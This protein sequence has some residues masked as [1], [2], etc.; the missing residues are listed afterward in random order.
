MERLTKI[1]RLRFKNSSE[2]GTS[3]LG[4]GFEK[5]DRGVFDPSKA[6]DKVAATGVKWIRL[7]SGWQRT[8]REKG[9]Y[10]W[11]WLD[12]VVDNLV[13]RGL[14]PWACLCYGNDLYSPEAKQYYGAV[15][16]PPIRTEEEKAAWHNYVKALTARYRGRMT[17]YE[18]WNEPDGKWCWKHGVN[19]R[20]YAQFVIDTARAVREG[21]PDAKV[22]GGSV[23]ISEMNFIAEAFEAGMGTAI[24]ALTYHAY[25]PDESTVA[26]R[27]RVLRGICDLYNPK[28]ELIQGESGSQSRSGGHGALWS[29]SWTQTKQAK[30]LLRHAMADLFTEAKF[31]SYFSC[32]DMI[33]A[34][35]GS[36]DNVNSILDYGYFGILG[37]DFDEKGFATGEYRPKDSYWALSSLATVFGGD[38]APAALPVRRMKCQSDRV[39]G[40]DNTLDFDVYS[41]GFRR[42]DGSAA[43]VYWKSTN[44]MTTA[45]DGTGTFEVTGLKD[46]PRLVDLYDGS[47]YEFPETLIE[48]EN[49]VVYQLKNIPLRD[50]PLA[51][52]FGNFE[53]A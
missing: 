7:Q 53:Q 20:E 8:E 30:Q 26:E 9:V 42:A 40:Q 13:R 39:H 1:G 49:D 37:A 48:R 5:L 41:G 22:I 17:Y 50:Y 27:A 35:N 29:G 45:F 12:D 3:R 24:D 38:F 34:L 33:E 44:L 10:D 6:Y 51:I 11:A 4:L 52:L 31:T 16:V 46:K 28:I 2:I 19:G 21:D 32:M 15:G 47:I 23:C 43:Y 36:P 18:V 25:T 14:Q